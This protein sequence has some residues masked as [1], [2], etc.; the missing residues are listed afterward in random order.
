LE[1]A[2]AEN[3]AATEQRGKEI[4]ISDCFYRRWNKK[5][6][7]KPPVNRKICFAVPAGKTQFP[8]WR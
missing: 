2:K 6:S 7:G 4:K 8:A 1:R 3:I 5:T